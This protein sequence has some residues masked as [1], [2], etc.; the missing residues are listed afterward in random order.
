MTHGV[1]KNDSRGLLIKEVTFMNYIAL[2]ASLRASIFCFHMFGGELWFVKTR[3]QHSRIL[4]S[5]NSI[6]VIV[7]MQDFILPIILN[8]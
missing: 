1:Y 3:R 7:H 4:I 6:F 8:I 2:G 5:S